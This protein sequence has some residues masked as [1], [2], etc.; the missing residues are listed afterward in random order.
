MAAQTLRQTPS[1]IQGGTARIVARMLA[2]LALLGA[3]YLF[4]QDW[5]RT[6]PVQM[7]LQ[8]YAPENGGWIGEP[9]R[10]ESGRQVELQVYT[11]EGVHSFAIAHTGVS[12]NSLLPGTKETVAFTAPA[13]GRY[14]LHCTTWCSPNHW[15]M[16]T[17][18]EVFDPARPQATLPYAQ[19]EQRYT[20]P[21][22]DM[23]LDAPHPAPIWPRQRP[24]AADGASIWQTLAPSSTPVQITDEL[25]WPLITPAQAFEQIGAGAV[26][27]LA[28]AAEGTEADRWALVAYLWQQRSTPDVLATGAFLYAE[29][30]ADCHGP[31]GAGDGYAAFSSPGVEPDFQDPRAAAGASPALY[32]AKT[33]RGGMGTGMP[34]WGTV[35]GEDDLWAVTEYLYTFFFRSNH[36]DPELLPAEMGEGH[37][38]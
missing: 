27:A 26:R 28:G 17:I 5:Q 18:L 23:D 36:A 32:Y 16:R 15:R 33:S 25:G 29:N 30:C 3:I 21:L 22:A 9:L 13:P 31:A 4:Q 1:L 7:R 10:V 38:H 14:V 8:A 12:S 37:G 35:L 6:R 20:L 34:N 19:D 24:V 11:M 2:L